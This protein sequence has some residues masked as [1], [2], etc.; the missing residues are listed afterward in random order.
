MRSQTQRRRARACARLQ[1]VSKKQQVHRAVLPPLHG[2]ALAPA[3]AS[4]T[5]RAALRPP[6]PVSSAAVHAAA[7]ATADAGAAA[8]EV[9][10]SVW[11]LAPYTLSPLLE[12]HGRPFCGA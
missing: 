4:R 5:F 2:A 8:L 7:L 6:A 9:L 11:L 1:P 10:L 12:H 3:A